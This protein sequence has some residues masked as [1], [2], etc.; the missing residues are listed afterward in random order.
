MCKV[1]CRRRKENP[2]HGEESL[3]SCVVWQRV[4]TQ[5]VLCIANESMLCNK[6]IQHKMLGKTVY[7]N[8]Q[9]D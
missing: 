6:H 2:K 5:Q 8:I 1:T 3:A 9:L 4:L 7:N